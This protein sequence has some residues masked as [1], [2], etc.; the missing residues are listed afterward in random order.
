MPHP[1]TNGYPTEKV[2]GIMLKPNAP[3]V[4]G[5]HYI[6]VV[7]GS[8]QEFETGTGAHRKTEVFTATVPNQFQSGIPFHTILMPSEYIAGFLFNEILDPG[9][10]TT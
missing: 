2:V 4:F 10:S 7:P 6:Q 3:S 5:T 1:Y 8:F 9:E